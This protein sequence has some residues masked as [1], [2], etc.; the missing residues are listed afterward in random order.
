[1]EVQQ[2]RPVGSLVDHGRAHARVELD[3][4]PVSH[5]PGVAQEGL[6]LA[7]PLALV[8]GR[9]DPR[10]SAHPFELRRNDLGVVEDE[11]VAGPQQLGQIEHRPIGN[12]FAVDQQQP[13]LVARA[14]RAQRDPF[15]GQFEIEIVDAHGGAS[16]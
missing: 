7:R 12:R 3:H 8:Q 9:A 11:H 2:R 5:P 15:G 1:M 16:D 4:V 13:R 10:L 6:P 14:R